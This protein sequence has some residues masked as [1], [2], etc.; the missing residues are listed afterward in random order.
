MARQIWL[1]MILCVLVVVIAAACCCAGFPIKQ[2]KPSDLAGTWRAEY[3][4][5]ARHNCSLTGV[6]T[7]TLRPDGTYQQVYED[8][9]GYV[10]TSPWNEWHLDHSRRGYLIVR[11][12]GGRFY[13]L[14][15]EDA[16]R[17]ARGELR[18]HVESYGGEIV[19]VDATEVI[20]YVFAT[21]EGPYLEHLPVCEPDFPVNVE[22]YRIDRY[23]RSYPTV[24]P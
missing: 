15:V 12:K 7:L 20:L 17:I 3:D 22:F 23:V 10:Y 11:L 19:T 5:Y 13:P 9:K 18:Y 8:R 14:G 6:E 2:I 21:R 16:E 1:Q 24:F 4:K